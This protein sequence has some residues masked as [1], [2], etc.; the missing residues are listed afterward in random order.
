MNSRNILK[1][2]VCGSNTLAKIQHGWLYEHPIKFNCGKCGILITGTCFQDPLEGTFRVE[3]QNANHVSELPDYY[4]EI[5]GELL[6]KKLE[7]YDETDEVKYHIPPFFTSQWRMNNGE[8]GAFKSQTLKFLYKTKAKW[9]NHRRVFELWLMKNNDY[10]SAEIHKNLPKRLFPSNNNL[11]YLRAVHFLILKNVSVVHDE[12][13]F[14][15]T[16]HEINNELFSLDNEEIKKLI[17]FFS[18]RNLFDKYYKKI[19][20]LIDKFM[21]VFK[22]LIPAVVHMC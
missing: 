18:E 10:L 13:F 11:E 5:S 4:I 12:K 20:D 2:E 7:V 9:H 19:I 1:C 16:V 14:S 8:I 3:F 21:D 15:R 22:F 17:K 6:S